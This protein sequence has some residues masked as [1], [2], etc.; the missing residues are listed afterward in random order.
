[1]RYTIQETDAET[2]RLIIEWEPR[3]G[4]TIRPCLI[5]YCLD[6]E[7][8]LAWEKG[9]V[10]GFDLIQPCALILL[11]QRG[12]LISV[13]EKIVGDGRASRT[14]YRIGNDLELLQF[15]VPDPG[16]TNLGILAR[17]RPAV[18]RLQQLPVCDNALRHFL[19]ET[20]HPDWLTPIVERQKHKWRASRPAKF[21][22]LVPSEVTDNE[23][24]VCVSTAPGAALRFF[25]DRISANDLRRCIGRDLEAA[26]QYAFEAMS[27]VQVDRACQEFPGLMVRHHASKLSE[28]RLLRCVRL[29]PFAGFLIRNQLESRLHAKVLA[30][31]LGLP[32]ELFSAGDLRELP[33]EILQSFLSHPQAWVDAFAGNHQR[34]LTALMRHRGDRSRGDYLLHLMEHVP[35]EY[36]PHVASF[37]ARFI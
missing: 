5:R 33:N 14:H 28:E 1:M 13:G 12:D 3:Q 37:A 22:H 31:T 15:E 7:G 23:I 10:L 32:F 34:L 6:H 18:P 19:A 20:N 29:D 30:G 21:F 4:K 26:A 9:V 24:P 35:P 17:L 11:V 36:L 27:E 8:C 16:R 2:A 25:R